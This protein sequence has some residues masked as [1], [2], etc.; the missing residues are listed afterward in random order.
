[1]KT[2]TVWIRTYSYRCPGY[3]MFHRVEIQAADREHAREQAIEIFRNWDTG[4]DM[5]HCGGWRVEEQAEAV[6][7]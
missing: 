4:S 5:I 3:D 2:W 6:A 1:M 7:A